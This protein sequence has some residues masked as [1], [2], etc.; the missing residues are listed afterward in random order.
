VLDDEAELRRFGYAQQLR[1]GM[2]AFGNFAL[3]FSIISIL[4]GGVSLYGYGLG[5]GGPIEMAVGWPLVSVMTLFVAV[6]LAELA[7]AYPTAGA[8]Y[9]WATIL[10]GPRVGW[11]TAWFNLIGQVAVLAGIDYAFADF[12]RD[13]LGIADDRWHLHLLAIYAVVLASHGLLNHFGIRLVTALNEL[14]AWYHLA[15]TALL[16]GALAWWAPLQPASF[17]MTRFVAPAA[18]KVVYPFAYACLIGLLQAQWTFTGYDASAHVAEETK[19]AQQA[20]PRG[21]VNAVWV[22]AVAGFVMLVMITLAIQDLDKATQAA[23]PFIYVIRTALG[24]RL[25]SALVWMVIGAMWF[26]GLSAVTSNSR[27][28][29]AFARDG[30]AP[31]S[32]AL[33]RV[34]ERH[35]T[36]AVAIWVCVATAFALAIWSSAY[37]VIVSIS[38]IGFYVSYGLPVVLALRARRGGWLERGPWNVGR[39]STVVNGIAVCWIAFISVLFVLPPNQLTGYTFAGALG[40]LGVYYFAWA[41]TKFEGPPA[42]KRL[43]EAAIPTRPAVE[44]RS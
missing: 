40:L 31:W 20:A 16:V 6:S 12:V 8:L 15:G 38:T 35:R 32:G 7:S 5:L 41:R 33:A 4:T 30:G 13:A 34:S 26:C 18:N 23:N 9:H 1:R 25:G 39:W 22:S 29:W 43:R 14:S 28:L 37:N 42:L 3:S 11:W 21:I 27:M 24:G 17:L 10:G 44:N 36:P 2:S 19:D